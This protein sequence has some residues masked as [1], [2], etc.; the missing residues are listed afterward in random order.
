MESSV[1]KHVRTFI[2]VLALVVIT[3]VGQA[4]EAPASQAATS[5]PQQTKK[6]N[7]QQGWAALLKNQPQA[8]LPFF[9]E[10]AKA[11]PDDLSALEGLYQCQRMLGMNEDVWQT[12]CKQTETTATKASGSFFLKR[13]QAEQHWTGRTA[14]WLKFITELANER[15]SPAVST[16]IAAT[17]RSQAYRQLDMPLAK[18]LL[19]QTGI[20]TSYTRLVGPFIQKQSMPDAALPTLPPE[21]DPAATAYPDF[22]GRAVQCIMPFE[23]DGSC[24][25]ELPDYVPF[26]RKDAVYFLQSAFDSPKGQ[27]VILSLPE[28]CKAWLNNWVIY[29]P[30]L[31]QGEQTKLV[32]VRLIKGVNTLLVRFHH[33]KS[34]IQIIGEDGGAVGGLKQLPFSP[35]DWKPCADTAGWCFSE[36]AEPLSLSS[37]RPK[38]EKP[39]IHEMLWLA[40]ALEDTARWEEAEGVWQKLQETYPDSAL[41]A[42]NFGH[43]L[44]R[45]ARSDASSQLRLRKQAGELFAAAQKSY[46]KDLNAAIGLAML[47]PAENAEG[48]GQKE[49]DYEFS[50]GYYQGSSQVPQE[51]YLQQLSALSAHY[52]QSLALAKILALCDFTNGWTAPA[53]AMSARYAALSPEDHSDIARLHDKAG[54]YEARNREWELGLAANE[55]TPA[56]AIRAL[57]DANKFTEAHKRLELFKQAVPSERFTYLRLLRRLC[58]EEKDVKGEQRAIEAYITAYPD[59]YTGYYDLGELA[60]RNGQTNEAIRAFDSAQ[61]KYSA[62]KH[63]DPDFAL[64]IDNL[65]DLTPLV[66]EHDLPLDLEAVNRVTKK[67][68]SRANFATMLR[69]RTVRIYPGFTSESFEHHAVKI[70]DK[71]GIEAL[72]ELPLPASGKVITCRTVQQNGDIFVPDSAENVAFGKAMSMYNVRPGSTLDYSF[73]QSSSGSKSF[74]DS[75]EFEDFDTPVIRSRYTVMLPKALLKRADITTVPEDFEPEISEE[76]DLVTLTWDAKDQSGCEREDNLP[77]NLSTLRSV[78]I[79]IPPALPNPYEALNFF[80]PKAKPKPIPLPLLAF[81]KELCRGAKNDAEKTD[82]IYQWIAININDQSQSDYNSTVFPYDTFQIRS[83]TPGEKAALCCAMLEA[84]GVTAYMVETNSS[85]T[86]AGFLSTLSDAKSA[87]NFGDNL[88]L[89]VLLPDAPEDYWLDFHNEQALFRQ[90]DIGTNAEGQ[91]TRE[92]SPWGLSLEYIRPSAM[93]L[94]TQRMPDVLEIVADGSVH[95]SSSTTFY[96]SAAAYVRSSLQNP[97]ETEK[98][99]QEFATGRYQ[100]ITDLRFNHNTNKQIEETSISSQ[101]VVLSYKGKIR[102]FCSRSGNRLGFSVFSGNSPYIPATPLPRMNPLYLGEEIVFS[103]SRIYTAPEGWGFCNIPEDIRVES[104]FGVAV[105]DCNVEGNILSA[106]R[107]LLI[108]EQQIEPEECPTYNKFVG[109]IQKIDEAQA[110]LLPLPDAQEI[111]RTKLRTQGRIQLVDPADLHTFTLPENL[112]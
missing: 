56:E 29:T 103:D 24:N 42:S 108:P 35:D 13:L 90:R 4:E 85:I 86:S 96:G 50:S 11:A 67:D 20:I 70:L 104:D 22:N 102:D 45:A 95:V 41:L 52:P 107:Y 106:S 91:L 31:F 75:F 8:A 73:R 16:L 34:Y 18:K 64:R 61:E 57:T 99:L 54:A 27:N 28:N 37:I 59:D 49:P 112:E 17:Q 77:P 55:F 78:Q 100:R 63:Y 32:R 66:L 84:M 1:G 36:I 74:D 69:L 68:H 111:Q 62:V 72:S 9:H 23:L 82:R 44:R 7:T 97:H 26:W 71:S 83:G 87:D 110:S 21:I 92:H 38:A 93:E 15:P 89:K 25:A 51:E 80:T 101:S 5:A 58:A 98:T 33:E 14:S 6:Q 109:L 105:L 81:C 19:E 30:E 48:V 79:S 47:N 43:F 88:L 60:V 10:A 3:A 46:P 12:L 39:E 40:E 76:G 65:Q 2:M 53:L 94:R